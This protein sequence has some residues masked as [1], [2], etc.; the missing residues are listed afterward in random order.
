M[1]NDEILDRVVLSDG[2]E[3]LLIKWDE[4]IAIE[5]NKRSLMSSHDHASEDALG[6]IVGER[7]QSIAKPRVLIGGL[8]LGFTL[9]AALDVMPKTARVEVVEVVPAVV[10]WNREVF[11]HLARRPL[12]DPRVKVTIADVSVVIAQ[13]SG[14]DAILLDVDNGPVALT[15]R[16]NTRLYKRAGLKRAKA[17][18]GPAGILAVWSAF[19][20]RLFTRWLREV[21]FEVEVIRAAATS[22]GGPRYYIWIA[23]R[24]SSL[25]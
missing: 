16:S 4:H 18:L 8:G 23:R 14:Y 13:G 17:A 24:K 9:R 6:R 10:R 11:G 5:V 25:K 7:V 12:G 3:M 2:S 15:Q 22:P 1:E 20:S 19:P 21:G